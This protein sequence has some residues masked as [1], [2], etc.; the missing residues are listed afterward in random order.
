M[1]FKNC[2][3]LLL[4][5]LLN[6]TGC[7]ITE[8]EQPGKIVESQESSDLDDDMLDEFEDETEIQERY[9]P[10][11]GYNRVMTDFNDNLYV[12]ILTPTADGYKYLVN[13]GV[14]ESV[15][16]F[17]NNLYFPV[18]FVNNVLQGKLSNATE[19]T[20]RF[21]VNTTI[22]ILGLFD[23]AKSEFGLEAHK[24]DFGQTLGFYGVGSGPHI[25]LPFFGPSNLRDTISMVPDSYLSPIDYTD[26]SWITLTDTWPEYLATR[27]YDEINT[28][29][30]NSDQYEK[31]KEDAVD[32]YPY[33]RDIYEQ[34]RDKQIEE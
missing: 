17:F 31:L 25:V 34:Y 8:I 2:V 32:L 22:G 18:R 23:V 7:A 28:F 16:N 30:L 29:S 26:R 4:F 12:H 33:L 15:D 10:F 13:Q 6:F 5:A 3:F 1:R 24:E 9:D 19:E 21:I 14:R 11:N 20:G 27:S